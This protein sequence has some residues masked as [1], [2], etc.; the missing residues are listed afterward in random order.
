MDTVLRTAVFVWISAGFL[1]VAGRTENC[2]RNNFTA[3]C[4]FVFRNVCFEFVGEPKTYSQ[5][6]SSC[7]KQGG[8]LLKGMNNP[9]KIFLDNITRDWNTNFN[10]TWWLEKT[11]GRDNWKS[12]NSEWNTQTQHAFW[13]S[14]FIFC[15]TGYCVFVPCEFSSEDM[16]ERVWQTLEEKK[17]RKKYLLAV[18]FD[19]SPVFCF[20]GCCFLGFSY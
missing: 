16:S 7:E 13:C 15:C 5:A 12:T 17:K 3:K 9:T 4:E 11:V 14:N 8:E 18:W 1:C 6:R 2:P 10:H 19:P 20:L